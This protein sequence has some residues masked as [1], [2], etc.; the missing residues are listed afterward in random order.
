[1]KILLLLLVFLL[2]KEGKGSVFEQSAGSG[3]FSDIEEDE[4]NTETQSIT[5]DDEYDVYYVNRLFFL[6]SPPPLPT[7]KLLFQLSKQFLE[8]KCL[9]YQTWTSRPVNLFFSQGNVYIF[10]LL[11][12]SISH[13]VNG[14]MLLQPQPEPG[15]KRVSNEVVVTSP[16]STAPFPFRETQ[17]TIYSSTLI[18]LLFLTLLSIVGKY[19]KVYFFIQKLIIFYQFLIVYV[20]TSLHTPPSV[21]CR[22]KPIIF[23]TVFKLL[24]KIV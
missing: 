13:T 14:S 10:L 6:P 2:C 21:P 8:G 24:F 19:E 3:D 11:F 17:L 9:F 4:N 7:L 23:P 18:C 12:F 16:H 20:H 22:N 15:A 5:S 1:M